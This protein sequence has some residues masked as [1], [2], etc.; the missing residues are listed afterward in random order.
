MSSARLTRG[1]SY[2]FRWA[3]NPI[4]LTGVLTSNDADAETQGRKPRGDRG[5]ERTARVTSQGMPGTV[6][7]HGSWAEA[8]K[9]LP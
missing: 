1:R 4:R 6:S 5:R 9:G 8:E 7:S 2:G 3:L